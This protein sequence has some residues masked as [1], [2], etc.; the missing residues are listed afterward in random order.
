MCLCIYVP[1]QFLMFASSVNPLIQEHTS[2]LILD[3]VMLR[4]HCCSQT[5]STEQFLLGSTARQNQTIKYMTTG[6]S[7]RHYTTCRCCCFLHEQPALDSCKS[8]KCMCSTIVHAALVISLMCSP[9]HDL[10]SDCSKKPSLQLQ[11]NPPSV[12]VHNWSQL[13]EFIL[14]SLISRGREREEGEREEREEGREKGK[15]REGGGRKGRGREEG[16]KKGGRERGRERG[17][18]VRKRV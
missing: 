4:T 10:M 6:S 18:E 15:K 14:H 16:I 3:E 1:V 11:L 12:L 7:E 13:S 9:I 5:L 17:R 8:Y 2:I